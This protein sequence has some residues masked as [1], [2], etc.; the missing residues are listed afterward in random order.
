MVP[1]KQASADYKKGL[2]AGFPCL[3]Q[4]SI[5]QIRNSSFEVE[6]LFY[7]DETL[8]CRVKTIH[9]FCSRVSLQKREIPLSIHQLLTH[10][11]ASLN[12][13]K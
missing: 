11:E 10:S 9:V 1:I 3:I 7:Q 5:L 6:F 12:F 4:I 8:C 13:S 2:Q